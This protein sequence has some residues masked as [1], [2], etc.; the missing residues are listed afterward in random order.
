M[1]RL[2]W[3]EREERGVGFENRLEG[4]RG[5]GSGFGE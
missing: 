4:K 3:R 2:G 5:E 1:G